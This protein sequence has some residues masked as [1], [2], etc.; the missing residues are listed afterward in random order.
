[1]CKRWVL[2]TFLVT[3]SICSL[4][5]SRA[6]AQGV[7]P[8]SQQ[9]AEVAFQN[10]TNNLDQQLT[11]LRSQ[12]LAENSQQIRDVEGQI[13][14][15]VGERQERNEAEF[16]QSKSLFS[17]PNVYQ[18][19]VL[20]VTDR[21]RSPEGAFQASSRPNGE[22]E[23]GIA[24]TTVK[25][26]A[27]LSTELV[28]GAAKLSQDTKTAAAVTKPIAGMAA[29]LA[30]I[31]ARKTDPA[32]QPRRVLLFIH[33]YNNGFEEAVDDAAKLAAQ[34]QFSVIPIAFSWPSANKFA[35]Y[36]EDTDQVKISEVSFGDFLAELIKKSPVEVV[37]VAHS[38]GSRL[39]TA[40]LYHVGEVNAPHPQLKHVVYAA[41]D[42]AP[43]DFTRHWTKFKFNDVAFTFYS[44]N[45]DSALALSTFLHTFQRL[46]DASPKII[47][48]DGAYC[49]DASSVDPML[50]G[51]GHSYVFNSLPVATDIGIWVKTDNLPPQRGLIKAV[52]AAPPYYLFQ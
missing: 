47:A 20:Y 30:E 38:M 41:A 51:V 52:G 12:G 25:S 18:I 5:T 46:G 2:R 49:I 37:V 11:T 15:L 36:G 44:S 48:V 7:P 24:T 39:L 6:V 23:Y 42:I 8:V 17:K 19:P 3:L 29:L 21:N 33:G 40:G 28:P 10:Q 32:G 16:A 1:M 50:K 27:S 13:L 4:P 22:L 14:T 9:A 26:D 31:N 43:S 45:H 35:K 34:V